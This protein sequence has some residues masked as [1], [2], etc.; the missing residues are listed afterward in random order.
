MANVAQ[1]SFSHDYNGREV[2]T[3]IFYKPQVDVPAIEGLYRV[4][5]TVDKTNIYLPAKLTKMLR[6]YTTCGFSA[7]GGTMTIADKTISTE[8]IKAN[9]E[10]CADEFTDTIFAEV[11][12]TGVNVDDLSNTIV[13]EIIKTQFIK[14][15]NSDIHRIAWFAVDS[16]ASNIDYR[17]FDGFFQRFID[18]SATITS[19]RFIDL[20]ATA[21]EST[22]TGDLNV[23]GAYGAMKQMYEK[24][25][26]MLKV[27]SAKDKR[28]YV[29]HT[30]YDN[31]L[32]TYED[33]QSS[34]GLLRLIDGVE[35]LTFRGIP[36]I[37]MPE[38]DTNLAD[39]DNPLKTTI[40]KNLIVYTTPDNLIIGTDVTSPSSEFRVRYNDDDDEKMKVV[41]KFKLGT[42]F[43]H[44]DLLVVAY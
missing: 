19:A 32:T 37:A 4:I 43:V 24:S 20:Q 33:T 22:A 36:V 3:E 27:M 28:F 26:E 18:A 13:D 38:W 10:Q 30:V 16:T 6:K 14:G 5:S 29:T 9:V 40:G 15:I 7:A 23:D 41:A 1:T 25:T 17:Q 21:F 2:L 44:E 12:K 34:T 8:K 35:T 11:I 42:Q 39:T 31:L